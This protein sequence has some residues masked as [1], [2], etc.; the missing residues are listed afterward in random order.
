MLHLWLGLQTYLWL[1]IER[2][3]CAAC[4]LRSI[5]RYRCY[6]DIK[7]QIYRVYQ[8]HR[9]QKKGLHQNGL[10]PAAQYLCHLL[11]PLKTGQRQ[12]TRLSAFHPQWPYS[13]HPW[14]RLA[15]IVWIRFPSFF[16]L[17]VQMNFRRQSKKWLVS[18][19]E[20]AGYIFSYVFYPLVF[21][22]EGL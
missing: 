19:L 14:P 10:R 18:L 3:Q 22:G 11:Y 15:Y 12:L 6:P 2:S 1:D 4:H 16:L 20:R 13:H 21:S 9:I 7:Y 8:K 5:A 17:L